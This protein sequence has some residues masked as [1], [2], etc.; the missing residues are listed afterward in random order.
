MLLLHPLKRTVMI[1]HCW[2]N[3]RMLYYYTT[4]F[5]NKISSIKY[6]YSKVMLRI[7]GECSTMILFFARNVL[8]V[9]MEYCNKWCYTKLHFFQNTISREYCIRSGTV[10]EANT[11]SRYY[12]I[13]WCIIFQSRLH[14]LEGM[15]HGVFKECITLFAMEHCKKVMLHYNSFSKYIVYGFRWILHRLRELSCWSNSVPF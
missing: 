11:F 12:C 15:P 10:F 13:Y 14:F 9:L 2:T 3:I 4:R 5:N 6:I 7:S 8:L 1:Q